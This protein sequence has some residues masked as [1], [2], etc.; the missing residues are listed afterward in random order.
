MRLDRTYEGDNEMSEQLQ[1][2]A[3]LVKLKLG[4]WSG[5]RKRLVNR[6]RLEAVTKIYRDIYEYHLNATLPWDESGTRL[7]T[8]ASYAKY[9]ARM[10][11]LE[12]NRIEAVRKFMAN[13]HS[14][15]EEARYDLGE[16]FKDTDY[17]YAS[18]VWKKFSIGFE[19][20][21]VPAGSHFVADLSDKEVE[22]IRQD[23]ER[24]TTA[25]ITAGVADVYTRLGKTIEA[26]NL[27]FNEPINEEGNARRLSNTIWYNFRELA[28]A[29]PV[30]NITDDPGL[31]K[32]REEILGTIEGV[33]PDTLKPHKKA[34]DEATRDRV[35]AGMSHLAEMYSGFCH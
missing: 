24:H 4:Q 9:K 5:A 25:R 35:A 17:P 31:A 14:A 10:V 2:R 13:Y 19:F 29:V 3:M 8:T 28:D 33:D 21:P 23:I 6:K 22:R 12:I 7:L 32:L 11:A 18:E 26:L 27:Y 15:I 34:F 20:S 1:K 16:L 30:L